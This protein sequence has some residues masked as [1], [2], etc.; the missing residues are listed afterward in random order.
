VNGKDKE[1]NRGIDSVD[2]ANGDSLSALEGKCGKR[3]WVA[4][5]YD[6]NFCLKEKKDRSPLFWLLSVGQGLFCLG[7]C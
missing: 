2:E 6:R 5:S 1:N 3:L 4:G 7:F